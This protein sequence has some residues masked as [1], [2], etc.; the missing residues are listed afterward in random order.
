MNTY[1]VA[2]QVHKLSNDELIWDFVGN[3][4]EWIS[5]D[6]TTNYNVKS[7]VLN[8]T[9][10]A[11]KARF[12]PAGTYPAGPTSPTGNIYMYNFGYVS[13]LMA[14]PYEIMRG[15]G[16]N[17][18]RYAGLFTAYMVPPSHTGADIGFR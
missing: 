2:R 3:L 18:D 15:G 4:S 10:S 16:W 6:D 13:A 1:D 9:D 11:L 5:D 14:P 8:I 12:G 7:W 17:Y